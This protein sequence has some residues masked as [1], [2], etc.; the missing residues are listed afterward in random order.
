MQLPRGT[1]QAVKKNI[2]MADLLEEMKKTSFTGSCTFTI[3]G[4]PGSL[5]G[6]D[7]HI[8]LAAFGKRSGNAAME[9]LMA[10]PDKEVDAAIS[11]LNPAQLQL[12]L[13]F[14][15]NARITDPARGRKHVREAV[16][17]PPGIP[18]YRVPAE[19][20]AGTPGLTGEVV[21]ATQVVEEHD[22]V[23]SLI[24]S[25]LDVLDSMDLDSMRKKIRDN[26]ENT[27]RRLHL[28]YLLTK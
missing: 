8:M 22:E 28:E 20:P 23:V 27:I 21:T 26:C 3:G 15:R 14:N 9:D 6:R 1:F 11:L 12:A 10:Q 25:D 16:L 5:V 17:S 13:E 18:P 2:R 4:T 24:T 7:G 19:R